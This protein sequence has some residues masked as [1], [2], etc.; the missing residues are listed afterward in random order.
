MKPSQTGGPTTAHQFI[1]LVLWQRVVNAAVVTRGFEPVLAGQHAKVS[2]V[3]LRRQK[4]FKVIVGEGDVVFHHPDTAAATGNQLR[5][6]SGKQ[7]VTPFLLAATSDGDH[8]EVLADGGVLVLR[9]MLLH[10]LEPHD[11]WNT[12]KKEGS[13][14]A[15]CR[16]WHTLLGSQQSENDPL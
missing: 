2:T 11:P 12:G 9:A 14:R 16:S 5:K 10:I 15:A 3:A 8:G 6:P 1:F 13:T 4:L 7:N